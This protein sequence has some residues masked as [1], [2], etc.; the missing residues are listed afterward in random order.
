MLINP[1]S[2]L[3]F[4]HQPVVSSDYIASGKN[5]YNRYATYLKGSRNI[6]IFISI[7]F[8][9][10]PIAGIF[11]GKFFKNWLQHQARLTPGCPEIHQHGPF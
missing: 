8:Y 7:Y 1:L 9:K 2:K 3:F 11:C 10:L 5:F 6:R 4:P